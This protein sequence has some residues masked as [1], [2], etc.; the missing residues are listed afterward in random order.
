MAN[1]NN[2]VPRL[3]VRVLTQSGTL[4]VKMPNMPNRLGVDIPLLKSVTTDAVLYVPQELNESEQ[5]VARNNIGITDD[6]YEF[7]S[8]GD[9]DNYTIGEKNEGDG[10]ITP[11]MEVGG[12]EKGV[13]I[14]K[15]RKVN[16]LL[17]EMLTPSINPI[18][19]PP[20]ATI[21]TSATSKQRLLEVGSSIQPSIWINFTQGDITLEG[22]LQGHTAGVATDYKFTDGT[23]TT[24]NGDDN[25][26]TPVIQKDTEGFV[27]Y[28]GSVTYEGGDQPKD[29]DGNDYGTALE[30]GTM[31][32]SNSVSFEF[33]YPIYA[34]TDVEHLNDT[35]KLPLVSK[36]TGYVEIEFPLQHGG[37]TD[38]YTF[39]ISASLNVTEIKYFNTFAIRYEPENRIND[40]K[41]VNT[42]KDGVAY[43]RYTY[44]NDTYM[45]LNTFKIIWE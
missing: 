20:T 23:I 9:S 24:N 27:T 36:S 6:M 34:N 15:E 7:I 28:T 21:E 1:E 38:R 41:V 39:E 13:F 42:D 35:Y 25:S 31:N 22:V 30:G 33:V 11:T 5:S 44:K 37:M 18:I 3:K 45:E 26:I 14:E 17:R 40:F 12:I 10:G 8:T 29:S 2:I 19:T 16:Q 43:K 32:T 4:R